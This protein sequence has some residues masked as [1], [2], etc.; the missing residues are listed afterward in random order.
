M[1]YD[2]SDSEDRRGIA[3]ADPLPPDDWHGHGRTARAAA[4][5]AAHEPELT[6]F[7]RR[8]AASQ[9]VGDL[10]QELFRRFVSGRFS[11][12]LPAEETRPYLFDSARNL[13]AERARRDD[14]RRTAAHVEYDDSETADHC[15]HERLEM[16]DELARV[17]RAISK[18]KPRTRDI[19]LMH[20]FEGLSYEE[21]GAE[22]GMTAKGVEKQMAKAFIAIRRA[23]SGRR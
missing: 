3:A 22:M 12:P 18:L 4:A 13:L 9:D 5:Y 2:D 7:F 10:V 17:E 15:P 16:R 11:A 21:I 23:R 20:R 1:D 6:R 14:R 19:F 8:R